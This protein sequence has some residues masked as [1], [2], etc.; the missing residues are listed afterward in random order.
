[1][2]PLLVL[3]LVCLTLSACGNKGDLYL[4]PPAQPHPE[5]R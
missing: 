4:P 5:G 1:M 2:R 3:I